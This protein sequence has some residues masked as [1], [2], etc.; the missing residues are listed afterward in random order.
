MCIYHLVYMLYFLLCRCISDNKYVHNNSDECRQ[1]SCDPVSV[2]I[3]KHP[4]W[5]QCPNINRCDLATCGCSYGSPFDCQQNTISRN[6][7]HVW[8]HNLLRALGRYI[9]KD[10]LWLY[11]PFYCVF[12][13]SSNSVCV[14]YTDGKASLG[15]WL[16]VKGKR[17]SQ[18]GGKQV[19]YQRINECCQSHAK[20]DS[21]DVHGGVNRLCYMLVTVLYC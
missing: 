1:M 20:T 19:L 21:K 18:G 7:R 3:P 9:T 4:N 11:S 6:I 2:K 16:Q 10:G 8:T 5:T 14:L 13:S 15:Y 12:D 17:Q